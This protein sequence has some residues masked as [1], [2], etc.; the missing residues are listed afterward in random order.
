[1]SLSEILSG[2]AQGRVGFSQIYASFGELI[3]D[4]L[5]RAEI[6]AVLDFARREAKDLSVLL[7]LF[8]SLLLLLGRRLL[9]LVRSLAFFALGYAAGVLLFSEIAR[10]P[11]ITA[12]MC[13]A[14]ALIL[15]KYLY[16]LLYALA[17]ALPA[18]VLLVELGAR[19]QLSALAA[20]AAVLAAFILR[21][22]IEMLFGA[23]LGSV[24]LII[25]IPALRISL[26]GGARAELMLIPVIIGL[27]GIAV[28]LRVEKTMKGVR[29]PYRS[30]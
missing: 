20:L 30:E 29:A 6:A 10:H 9:P 17:S 13:A 7:L 28:Q 24:G 23:A 1:M 26:I 27:V 19:L 11:V 4:A 16:F 15:S 8:S 3:I 14:V 21:P 22:Y 25:S 12:L 2:L 5:S 18:F